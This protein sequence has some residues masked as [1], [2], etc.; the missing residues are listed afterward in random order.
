MSSQNKHELIPAHAMLPGM[1]LMGSDRSIPAVDPDEFSRKIAD[2]TKDRLPIDQQ[3]TF[4]AAALDQG[5]KPAEPHFPLQP[6]TPNDPINGD[7]PHP[8]PLTNPLIRF[9][10][11]TTKSSEPE[12]NVGREEAR[13]VAGEIAAKVALQHAGVDPVYEAA[14]KRARDERRQNK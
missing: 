5:F 2:A 9:I 3:R 7:L 8:T 12:A 13:R 6:G 11:S 14:L 4:S 1:E 10:E